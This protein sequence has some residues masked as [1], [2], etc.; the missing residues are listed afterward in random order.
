MNTTKR[1][2]R[3]IFH[4]LAVEPQ[5]QLQHLL[6]QPRMTFAAAAFVPLQRFGHYSPHH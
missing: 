5:P 2:Q 3:S 4:S 1:R 6:T